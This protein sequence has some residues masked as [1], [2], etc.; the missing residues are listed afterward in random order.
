MTPLEMEL[1]KT[2][3]PWIWSAMLAGAG[4]YLRSLN[5]QLSKICESLREF[6]RDV[7]RIEKEM[8]ETKGATQHKLDT[9]IGATNARLSTIET[10]CQAQ[11]GVQFKRRADDHKNEWA[12][13]SDVAGNSWV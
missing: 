7:A 12:Q 11:H 4:L 6:S 3:W 9:I 5:G 2:A 13:T 1:L 10:I 8:M